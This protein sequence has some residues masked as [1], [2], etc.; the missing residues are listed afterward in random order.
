MAKRVE[1][2][3][4]LI[5]EQCTMVNLLMITNKVKEFSLSSLISKYRSSSKNNQKKSSCLIQKEI[6]KRLWEV[7]K[8]SWT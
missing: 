4:K 2:E 8:P 5:K 7:F 3:C 1:R 6:S